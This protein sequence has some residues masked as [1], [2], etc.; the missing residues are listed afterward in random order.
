MDNKNIAFLVRRYLY[1][2]YELLVSMKDN[3]LSGLMILKERR[4]NHEDVVFAIKDVFEIDI[5][6]LLVQYPNII[7]QLEKKGFL[8]MWSENWSFVI[9]IAHDVTSGPYCED[10]LRQTLDGLIVENDSLFMSFQELD[11][12]IINKMGDGKIVV[13][14]KKIFKGGTND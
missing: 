4:N 11:N 10:E 13:V 14:P 7:L 9:R 1:A 6:E 3:S 8:E 12:K 2:G 5:T